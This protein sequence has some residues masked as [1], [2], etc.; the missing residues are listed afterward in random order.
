MP[1]RAAPVPRKRPTQA[2]AALTVDAIVTAVERILERDGARGLT[3]NR[4]AEVAG[5]R[6]SVGALTA[7]PSPTAGW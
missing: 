5:V 3:T 2:R 1:R 6:W 7:E 4:I